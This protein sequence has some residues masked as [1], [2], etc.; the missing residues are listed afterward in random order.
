MSPDSKAP[1]LAR[2]ALLVAAIGS[3]AVALLLLAAYLGIWMEGAF[4]HPTPRI[5]ALTVGLAFVPVPAVSWITYIWARTR[6]SRF[7][8]IVF[9]IVLSCVLL[10]G[11]GYAVFAALFLAF[12]VG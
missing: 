1:G 12:F 7:L 6:P 8:D 3:L 5:N 9:R 4:L 10:I 2:A 11:I